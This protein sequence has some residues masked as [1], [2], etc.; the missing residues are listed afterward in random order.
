MTFV[1]FYTHKAYQFF[2]L[3]LIS[4]CIPFSHGR[5][6]CFIIPYVYKGKSRIKSIFWSLNSFFV[7]FDP[8]S[9]NI[10]SI[11]L[12]MIHSE[13]SKKKQKF[14][15]NNN[16]EPLCWIQD[17]RPAPPIWCFIHRINLNYNHFSNKF[18]LKHILILY[19]IRWICLE[20]IIFLQKENKFIRVLFIKMNESIFQTF[21]AYTDPTMC[22]I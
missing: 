12:W 5:S 2:L 1:L 3:V 18:D 21:L 16:S 20:L 19:S 4:C 8:L 13:W 7:I 17:N 9:H 11:R 6:I 22:V 10:S 14:T 15:K